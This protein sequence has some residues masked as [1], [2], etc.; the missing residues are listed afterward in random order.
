M[1]VQKQTTELSARDCRDLKNACTHARELGR[2]LNTLVTFV[3]YPGS[4]PSPAARAADLNRLLSHIRVWMK[5]KFGKRLVALWVWHSDVT[6][7]NPRMCMSSCIARH[8]CETNCTTRW[9][10]SIRRA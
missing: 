3:P 4:K 8:V 7:R 1:Y 10:R 9:S 6:G 2:P 5:R